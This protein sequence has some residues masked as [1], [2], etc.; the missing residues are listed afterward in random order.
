MPMKMTLRTTADLICTSVSRRRAAE[1]DEPKDRRL[2]EPVLTATNKQTAT[3]SPLPPR[4]YIF[5]HL[6]AKKI[7]PSGFFFSFS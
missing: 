2:G 3:L 4:R 7:T 5:P 1:G 6:D